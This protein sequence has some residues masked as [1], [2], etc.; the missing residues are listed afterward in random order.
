MENKDFKILT[1]K[2]KKFYYDKKNT[3]LF[4]DRQVHVA[5]ETEIIMI[6]F[7]P[8]FLEKMWKDMNDTETSNEDH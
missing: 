2:K 7:Y 5:R 8:L 4:I 6:I 3:L 1:K